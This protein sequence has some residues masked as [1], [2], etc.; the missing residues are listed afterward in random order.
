M[1]KNLVS[2]WLLTV[3]AAASGCLVR[4]DALN[5]APPRVYEGPQ[6]VQALDNQR[7]R[8]A[9]DAAKLSGGGIQQ[10]SSALETSQF[11]AG[12]QASLPSMLPDGTLAAPPERPAAGKLSE[13]KLPAAPVTG[14]KPESFSLLISE[15]IDDLTARAAEI[16]SARLL[17]A[18]DRS[19]A[20]G[21]T[22]Y[23]V[24]F[25]VLVD[26]PRQNRLIYPFMW[27]DCT[28]HLPSGWKDFMDLFDCSGFRNY[29]K[30]YQAELTFVL[31]EEAD[32]EVYAVQPEKQAL[33]R[34][35]SLANATDVG[36]SLAVAQQFAAAQAE[37]RNRLEE[38]FAEQRAFPLIQGIIDHEKQFRFVFNPR[39]TIVRRGAWAAFVPFVP[40]NTTKKLLEPGVRRVYAYLVHKPKKEEK[41]AR[42]GTGG[43]KEARDDAGSSGAQRADDEPLTFEIRASRYLQSVVAKE[44]IKVAKSP[45]ERPSSETIH[46]QV[47]GRFNKYGNPYRTDPMFF[48]SDSYPDKVDQNDKEWWDSDIGARY[49][50]LSIPNRAAAPPSSSAETWTARTEGPLVIVDHASAKFAGSSTT[51]VVRSR[52]TGSSPAVSKLVFL[53]QVGSQGYFYLDP[54]PEA[55]G[56]GA[57]PEIRIFLK[58]KSHYGWSA[59]IPYEGPFAKPGDGKAKVSIDVEADD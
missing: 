19:L 53:N 48:L 30:D 28:G 49:I 12:L 26:P 47:F 10:F 54:L 2:I 57:Q 55:P 27:L 32:I 20:E 59:W 11:Q 25:D 13:A 36:A 6:V 7:T 3:S 8:V 52:T 39:R 18:G 23:L 22:L 40:R 46:L 9:A 15:S 31:P 16:E 58:T 35:D 45:E 5:I 34:L 56:G 44:R 33:T 41:N 1:T 43:G 38:A 50:D 17:Y 14:V 29:Q 21:G 24:R 51:A 37:Y 4:Q 42:R